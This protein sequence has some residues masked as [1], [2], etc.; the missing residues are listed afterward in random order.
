MQ[1]TFRRRAWIGRL[2]VADSDI[3]VQS[4]S[5]ADNRQL[6]LRRSVRTGIERRR[7]ALVDFDGVLVLASIPVRRRYLTFANRR[8]MTSQDVQVAA[9]V[10]LR[11][12]LEEVGQELRR[13][14][15]WPVGL[16][17]R[18]SRKIVA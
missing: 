3:R 17:G 8:R 18:H 2:L 14:F 13:S 4:T 5:L 11:I 7:D 10:L 9:N 16:Y 12:E 1:L 15:A 6:V